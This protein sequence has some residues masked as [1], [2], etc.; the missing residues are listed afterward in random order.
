MTARCFKHLQDFIPA[1]LCGSVPGRNST[2]LAMQLQVELEKRLEENTPIA[3]AAFD[4][5]KAF[6]TLNRELLGSM[7]A[8]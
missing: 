2:D 3:G 8:R 6:N 1:S 5:H 7:C 4:L